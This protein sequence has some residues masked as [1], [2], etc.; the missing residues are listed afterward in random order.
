M[1]EQ[2][3]ARWHQMLRVDNFFTSTGLRRTIP[4]FEDLLSQG[5]LKSVAA[6]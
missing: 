4:Y 2:L 5:L 1:A 6:A 3:M